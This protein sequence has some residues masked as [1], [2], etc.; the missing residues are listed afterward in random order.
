MVPLTLPI[1][2]PL[3]LE[4]TGL[5]GLGPDS[6]LVGLGP[7]WGWVSMTGFPSKT[8]PT[9][10]SLRGTMHLNPNLLIFQ[11]PLEGEKIKGSHF[12]EIHTLTFQF[13]ITPLSIALTNRIERC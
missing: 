8:E 7:D 9:L 12:T 10:K 11:F 1:P 5:A 6:C 13:G 4:E 2:Q 3:S